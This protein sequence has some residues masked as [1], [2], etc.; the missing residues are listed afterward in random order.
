MYTAAEGTNI[1][2]EGS[3]SS[4]QVV[5]I[6]EKNYAKILRNGGDITWREGCSLL[7]VADSEQGQESGADALPDNG[8]GV[9]THFGGKE[10]TE[11][12]STSFRAR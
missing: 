9:I 2:A 3:G 1:I 11:R 12:A 4:G 6:G 7:A 8:T 5:C 10:P